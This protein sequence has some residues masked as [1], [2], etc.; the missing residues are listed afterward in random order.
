MTRRLPDRRLRVLCLP[1]PH[2]SFHLRQTPLFVQLPERCVPRLVQVPQSRLTFLLGCRARF[3]CLTLHGGS[4]GCLSGR[5]FPSLS[6]LPLRVLIGHREFPRHPF[7][8]FPFDPCPLGLRRLACLPGSLGLLSGLSIAFGLLRG[9]RPAT[10]SGFPELLHLPKLLGPLLRP[11]DLADLRQSFPRPVGSIQFVRSDQLQL[12][13]YQRLSDLHCANCIR[14]R[15]YFVLKP[16]R[17]L[18]SYFAHVFEDGAWHLFPRNSLPS[19]LGKYSCL[20]C[21]SFSLQLPE[22]FSLVDASRFPFD[23]VCAPALGACGIQY[24]DT[25]SD[26][27]RE[28][29]DPAAFASLAPDLRSSEFEVQALFIVGQSSPDGIVLIGHCRPPL[30]V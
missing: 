9:I 2:Q 16:A 7:G 8:G 1:Q 20:K 13:R 21:R 11:H 12:L 29:T 24:A 14:P 10:R 23:T 6:G 4:V 3:G 19:A 28:L 22:C 18:L 27:Y 26:S 5:L 17:E 25:L 30:T 15:Y